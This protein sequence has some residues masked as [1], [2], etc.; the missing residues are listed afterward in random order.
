MALLLYGYAVLVLGAMA[1]IILRSLMKTRRYPPGPPGIPVLGNLHKFNQEYRE[2]YIEDIS[3]TYGDV[4]FFYNPTMSVLVLSS[5]R[6]MQDLLGNR[7]SIYSDR[8]RS[9]I[10]DMMGN[11]NLGTEA[12][13]PSWKLQRKLFHHHMN[14]GALPQYFPIVEQESRRCLRRLHRSPENW[15]DE[16]RLNTVRV[17]LG[18]TYDIWDFESP[19]DERVTAA[20]RFITHVTSALT[21]GLLWM[22]IFPIL[23]H[24]PPWVPWLGNETRLVSAWG[25]EDRTTMTKP[26]NYVKMQ[27]NAGTAKRSFVLSLLEE[28]AADERTMTWLAA[29]MYGGGAET[30]LGLLHAFVLAMVLHPD[31]QRKAQHEIER[32]VGSGRL[33]GI[34]D[35]GS[36]PY[37]ENLIREVIRWWSLASFTLGHRVMEDDEYKGYFIPKETIVLPCLWCISRDEEMYPEPETFRPERFD[38]V[39]PDGQLPLDPLKFSFGMGRRICPGQDFAEMVLFSNIA[40]FLATTTVSKPLDAEGNQITPTTVPINPMQR[41]PTPF[42]CRVE[43]RPAAAFLADDNQTK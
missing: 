13:G 6:A 15:M 24:I 8:P 36:L 10:I 4:M 38:E 31:V 12:F 23:R 35:R 40:V 32:V 7:G 26:F 18:V 25:E 21:P 43:V 41:N 16:L 9:S 1:L 33:P 34:Q 2:K 19:D 37:V 42:K 11:G 5:Y 29:S 39:G 28:D 3:K 30:T 22:N 14:K 27:K 17:I 20:S